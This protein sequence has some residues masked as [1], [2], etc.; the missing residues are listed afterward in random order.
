MVDANESEEDSTDD[1]L[2]G[3]SIPNPPKI[4]VGG[5]LQR[6]SDGTVVAPKIRQRTKKVS[7]YYLSQNDLTPYLDNFCLME[8]KSTN[9]TCN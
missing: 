3:P 8:T 6:N 1:S 7:L 2:E 4:V 9:E 5:A